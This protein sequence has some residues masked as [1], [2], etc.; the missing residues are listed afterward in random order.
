MIAAVP[1]LSSGKN[2]LGEMADEIGERH[3]ARQDEGG[4]PREQ[5]DHQQPS[6][7]QFESAGGPVQRNSSTLSNIV[8]DGNLKT[9]T[10]PY[11]NSSKPV[12]KRKRLN[13]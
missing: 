6:E 1:P 5:A 3:F 12:M 13:T 9:L 11:W 7:H 2:A 8:P 10:T 4:D